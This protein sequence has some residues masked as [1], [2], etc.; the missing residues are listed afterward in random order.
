MSQSV[1]E[2][3]LFISVLVLYAVFIKV[4]VVK[5]DASNNVMVGVVALSFTALASV[6]FLLLGF[7][8]NVENYGQPVVNFASTSLCDPVANDVVNPVSDFTQMKGGDYMHQGTDAL[9]KKYQQLVATPKGRQ[10]VSANQ[11]QKIYV[12]EPK[13]KFEYTSQTSDVWTNTQCSS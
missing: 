9:S 1:R 8:K 3:I 5:L 7:N 6:L 13:A 11:C 10:A 4:W 2:L 12:G